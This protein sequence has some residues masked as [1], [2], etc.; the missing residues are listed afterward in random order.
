MLGHRRKPFGVYRIKPNR[1]AGNADT[2]VFPGRLSLYSA[3]SRSGTANISL[4]YHHCAWDFH[5]FRFC[6]SHPL[7]GVLPSCFY[8]GSDSHSSVKM[9]LKCH[10]LHE[11]IAEPFSNTISL[12]SPLC[13]D[14][15]CITLRSDDLLAHFSTAL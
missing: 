10:F 8:I 11:A 7:P 3:L 13:P 12:F 1:Q 9:L 15:Q 2:L 5:T 6:I 14:L 4:F